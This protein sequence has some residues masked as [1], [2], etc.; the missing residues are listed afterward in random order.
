[1]VKRITIVFILT[2]F[3][4]IM[5]GQV[6][7]QMQKTSVMSVRAEVV[8]GVI[9]QRVDNGGRVSPQSIAL[10][11]GVFSLRAAHGTEM[12]ISAQKNVEMNC[13][14]EIWMMNSEMAVKKLSNGAIML[15]FIAK[16]VFERNSNDLH[17][18]IQSLTIEYL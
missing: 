13:D 14:K 17:R 9:A 6:H 15:R 11:Y 2:V 12:L 18:G 7:A 16:K 1:M 3:G 4:V 5:T 8:D 10:P